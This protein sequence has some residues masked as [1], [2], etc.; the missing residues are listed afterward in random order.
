MI[1]R[2]GKMKKSRRGSL[3]IIVV[4]VLA[5]AI[6]F[7]SSAMMLTQ[8]TKSRLYDNAM[9]SQARLTV[10]AAS[11]AFLEALETQEIT[12]D[13]FDDML[14]GEDGA[15]IKVGQQ[16]EDD[17][18]W[19]ILDGVPGMS[20][21]PSNC[22]RLDLYYPEADNY[23]LV[24]AD[25]TTTI[26]DETEN[27]QIRLKV[28]ETTPL[29]P[30]HGFFN[31]VEVESNVGVSQMRFSSGVGMYDADKLTAGSPLDNTLF[32][33]DNFFEN[34]SSNSLF[35]SD[36]VVDGKQSG[37]DLSTI[38]C[39]GSNTGVFGDLIFL[40]NAYLSCHAGNDWGINGDLYFIGDAT[41]AFNDQDTAVRVYKD[42]GWTNISNSS[43]FIFSGR[44]VQENGDVWN[45]G[46]GAAADS[47]KVEYVL[48]T[49]NAN[50]AYFVDKNGTSLA[51][52]TVNCTYSNGSHPYTVKNSSLS[53]STKSPSALYTADGSG[54]TYTIAQKVSYYQ[55]TEYRNSVGSF[56]TA[57]TMFA[58]VSDDL[59]TTYPYS[60]T[61]AG[62]KELDE[63]INAI[64]HVNANSL[65]SGEYIDLPA[66]NYLIDSSLI[67]NKMP[68]A[69][70]PFIIA[71]DGS[72]EYRFYFKSNTQFEIVNVLFAM[73]NV[74]DTTVPPIFVLEDKAKVLLGG[75]SQDKQH[76]DT[77]NPFAS[78][79]FLSMDRGCTSA[80]ALKNKIC[81]KTFNALESAGGEACKHAKKVNATTNAVEEYWSY[82]S[83]GSPLIYSK[84]YDGVNKPCIY[85]YGVSNNEFKIS[86]GTILEGYVGIFGGGSFG[87][88][89]TKKDG[90][91]IIPIY[92][93]I[94][95]S[96]LNN[97]GTGNNPM[98]DLCMPYCPSPMEA[99]GLNKIRPAV[100]K[101]HVTDVIYYYDSPT[102]AIPEGG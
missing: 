61:D 100:T 63:R 89:E 72:K 101:Y 1:K 37:D 46:D 6:I 7:I 91:K 79:G 9:S 24:H 21:D 47:N 71:L 45:G 23:N 62:Y 41:Q 31:Q 18:M 65:P 40:E 69:G 17:W 93:R 2:L 50:R 35:F 84:Y 67:A 81:N 22:T 27:V 73:Y 77:T 10:T 30:P 52:T 64:K 98:G 57:E 25:F 3:L 33:R 60:S 53:S 36:I 97:G 39:Y 11:E 94:M 51:A 70:D 32:F 95:A 74:S 59:T 20:S 82:K 44:R 78:S 66:G 12:D 28:D 54:T 38:F 85:I 90:G 87:V 16:S 43:K 88:S 42:G 29:P 14:L 26:G 8:A 96:K 68:K 4:L 15:H 34:E 13:Q 76:E 5:L 92:G 80:G 55:S 48:K 56:P 102:E 75:T 99:G 86:F 19:M 58:S 83:T 49:A